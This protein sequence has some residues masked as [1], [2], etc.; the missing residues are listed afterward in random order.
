MRLISG[1]HLS[2]QGEPVSATIPTRVIF[3]LAILNDIM[4]LMMLATLIYN[5]E[6]FIII[7]IEIVSQ[8]D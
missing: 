5:S 6:K 8:N 3:A 1:K 2:T 7:I 4:S